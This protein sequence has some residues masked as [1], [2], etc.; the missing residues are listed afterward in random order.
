MVMANVNAMANIRMMM[1]VWMWMGD[2][3][4]DDFC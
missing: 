1:K 4:D 3:A 2:D